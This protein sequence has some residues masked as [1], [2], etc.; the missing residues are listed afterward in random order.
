MN[1]RRCRAAAMI[2]VATGLLGTA[3][4]G[5]PQFDE[6]TLGAGLGDVADGS[7]GACPSPAD[8]LAA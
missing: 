5:E 7:T 2:A 6:R 4:G 1:K 8:R 3:C